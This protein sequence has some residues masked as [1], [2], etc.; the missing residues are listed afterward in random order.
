M[1]KRLYALLALLLVFSMVLAA[2]G[3]DEA[4][5]EPTTAPEPA[6]Q[7]AATEAPAAVE[8]TQAPT[9]PAEP[10]APAGAA[11]GTQENPLIQVFVPSGETEQ[12][13][14]G[15][16]ELDALLQERASTSIRRSPPATLRPSRPCVP[17]RQTS[18][19]LQP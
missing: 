3:S 4:T 8:P 14:T 16:S 7:T 2:C 19:G 5:P 10:A 6:A 17:A 9:E 18:S 1:H 13:M 12:I 11:K 15:A